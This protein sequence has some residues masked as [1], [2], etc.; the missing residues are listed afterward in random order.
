MPL[1]TALMEL[2]TLLIE[3]LDS[4]RC[5]GALPNS[6]RPILRAWC[7]S[8]NHV[9]VLLMLWEAR[10]LRAPSIVD[11]ARESSSGA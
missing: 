8:L 2:E 9:P 11:R 7:S 3:S 5:H 1:R 10:N 6:L 4:F